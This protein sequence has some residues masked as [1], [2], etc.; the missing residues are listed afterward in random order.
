MTV[1][2][3][4]P[5]WAYSD[6]LAVRY[7]DVDAQGHLYFANYL[8]YADEVAGHY[9]ESLGLAVMNTAQ[10][11]CF[12]FT[13]NITCDY[14]GECSA[15]Q[16]VEVSVAYRR[17]GNSSAELAFQLVNREAGALLARGSITQVFVDKGTRRPCPIPAA[18]R[19]AMVKA[20][21]ALA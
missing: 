17:L 18:Y 14:V 7:S 15:G 10:A 9:M 21:P 8:I 19:N 5:D 13:A 4:S 3:E 20:Q 6:T 11:P 1:S 16:R 12:F 2:D